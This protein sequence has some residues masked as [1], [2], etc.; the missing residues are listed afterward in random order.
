MPSLTI[1]Q[2]TAYSQ[3]CCQL[4]YKFL[5]GNNMT[6]TGY[7][8]LRNPFLNKGTAFS[9][10]EREQFGLTGT[11]PSQVQTIEEQADQAYKQFQAKSPLL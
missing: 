2:M 4:K 6:T 8:I 10:A 11:L 9:T 1:K 7:N 3:I 5:G